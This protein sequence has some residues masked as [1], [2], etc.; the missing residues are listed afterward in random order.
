MMTMIKKYKVE[1]FN[2]GKRTVIAVISAPAHLDEQGVLNHIRRLER[3]GVDGIYK[4]WANIETIN[5]SEIQS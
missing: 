2:A 4:P 3:R 5:F 1:G